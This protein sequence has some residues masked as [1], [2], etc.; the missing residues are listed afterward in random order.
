METDGR[1]DVRTDGRDL[2]SL[3][4]A[5]P[6]RVR[7]KVIGDQETTVLYRVDLGYIGGILRKLNHNR[8]S[9]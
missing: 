5:G 7:Q 3:G 4:K 6:S 1:T 8:Q 9:H 2:E